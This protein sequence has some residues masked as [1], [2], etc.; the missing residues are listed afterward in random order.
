MVEVTLLRPVPIG[1]EQ[2]GRPQR[3]CDRQPR[4]VV[5]TVERGLD[6]ILQAAISAAG[7]E[8]RM[9]SHPRRV[10]IVADAPLTDGAPHRRASSRSHSPP[11]R[12]RREQGRW[13]NVEGQAADEPSCDQPRIQ[14]SARD[15]PMS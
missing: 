14:A 7:M 12:Y 15:A 11:T 1:D 3:R 4:Q 6:G 5:V 8:A 9:S 10:A 13:R 2:H